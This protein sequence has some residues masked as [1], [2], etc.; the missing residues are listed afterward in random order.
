[1]TKKDRGHFKNGFDEIAGRKKN[2]QKITQQIVRKNAAMWII[3]NIAKALSS[4]WTNKSKTS[5]TAHHHHEGRA[6]DAERLQPGYWN[7]VRSC[8]LTY[9]YK[10]VMFEFNRI[11]DIY[12]LQKRTFVDQRKSVAAVVV[13]HPIAP[14]LSPL[15]AWSEKRKEMK[16][17]YQQDRSCWLMNGVKVIYLVFRIDIKFDLTKKR[18]ELVGHWVDFERE[19]L[20]T[21]LPVSVYWKQFSDRDRLVEAVMF[22]NLDFDQHDCTRLYMM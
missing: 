19:T 22:T 9:K 2:R 10:K 12:E 21:S 13:A 5:M 1:M 14:L 6:L 8:R 4:I 7:H 17:S 20:H 15:C 18:L 11:T 3:K 16:W